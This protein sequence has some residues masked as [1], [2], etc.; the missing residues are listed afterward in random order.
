MT[1]M[2][3]SRFVHPWAEERRPIAEPVGAPNELIDVAELARRLGV[4]RSTVYARSA[5]FGA[6]RLGF[7]PRAPLRFDWAAV[8]AA[9][10][11]AGPRHVAPPQQPPRPTHTR[12]GNRL[13]EDHPLFLGVLG[14][15]E[16][17][18]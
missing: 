4:A 6:I 7:G 14:P 11:K 10:P 13:I 2:L 5:A 12:A 16:L 18:Q 3:C 9:L 15:G 1:E 17:A 8:L